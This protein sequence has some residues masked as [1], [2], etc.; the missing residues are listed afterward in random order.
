MIQQLTINGLRGF[1]APQTIKLAVPNG[2]IGSGL[3]VLVGPNNGG[4]STIVEALGA[5]SKNRP[6][7]FTI[8]KRNHAAGDRV[9]LSAFDLS[10]NERRLASVASGTS[11]SRYE[12]DVEVGKILIVP[13]RRFFNPNFGKSDLEREQYIQNY[14]LPQ[15]RGS[16]VDHFAGRLFRIQQ[17]KAEF[18][19][20][21]KRVVDPVPAWTIDQS[22]QG[23]Y[24]IKFK[25]GPTYHT[26]DGVGDGLV[27]LM[28]VVDAL[29]DSAPEHAVAIDEPELSLHPAYQKKLA[30]L[31]AD[32]AKD[33]QIIVATHSPYFV[34]ISAATSGGEIARVFRDNAGACKI[35]PVSRAALNQ[36]KGFLTNVNNPHILGLDAREVFFLE[37]RII[38]VE[39]QEDVVFYQKLLA[40]LSI[41]LPGNF[42][43]WGAG[44]ADNIPIIAS[45]L[46]DLGFSKM[47]GI[48]DANKKERCDNL[49][50]EFPEF[51]FFCIP[52][53][54]IRTKQAQ[55]AR[56]AI[57]GLLDE[58][59]LVRDTYVEDVKKLMTDIGTFLT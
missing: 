25:V 40:D 28:F 5:L 23:P 9:V 49:N 14:D 19:E 1:A 48:L 27:S 35:S 43:G 10:G 56:N 16:P 29:Y 20:V 6:Q 42:F 22:D 11:E 55:P 17:H 2:A 30:L 51:R 53:D 45:V 44:G 46:K 33:R 52:A 31:L 41:N 8:G 37:D 47:I 58:Q 4:K 54:D 21:F 36:L 32:Y 34:D 26:S 50:A 7:S 13:S 18:D 15:F 12:A 24:F 59:F 57:S 39:G 3:T 38:L